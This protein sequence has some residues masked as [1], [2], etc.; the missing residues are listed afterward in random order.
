MLRLHREGVETQTISLNVSTAV[1]T[2]MAQAF[3]AKS[4][5]PS[6]SKAVPL[7]TYTG[8]FTITYQGTQYSYSW[9]ISTS[10]VVGP[11]AAYTYSGTVTIQGQ[12]YSFSASA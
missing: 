1:S 4:I 12:T 3:A 10:Y 7:T 2:A 5:S 9:N 6:T 11:P 8:N